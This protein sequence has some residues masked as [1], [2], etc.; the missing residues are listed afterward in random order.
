MT[1]GKKVLQKNRD[2]WKECRWIYQGYPFIMTY[3]KSE[4][5][6]VNELSGKI[7]TNNKF[8]WGDK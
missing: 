4:F 8:N 3:N 1:K 5:Y 2:E 6:I 7:V